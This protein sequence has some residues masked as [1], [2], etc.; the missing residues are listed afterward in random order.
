MFLFYTPWKQQETFDFLVFLG[1][2][3]M[4]KLTGNGLNST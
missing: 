1:G 4:G 3:K 2:Y